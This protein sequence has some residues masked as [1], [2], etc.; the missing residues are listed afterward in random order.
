MHFAL[1][2]STGSRPARNGHDVSLFFVPLSPSAKT[3]ARHKTRARGFWQPCGPRLGLAV[4]AS[5]LCVF[6]KIW[7]RLFFAGPS[8]C[9]FQS[10][11]AGICMPLFGHLPATLE[12]LR[13][14]STLQRPPL[15]GLFQLWNFGLKALKFALDCLRTALKVYSPPVLQIK[16]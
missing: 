15:Q 7:E 5:N 2:Y 4:F 11:P 9:G 6:S 1:T 10:A 14:P 16:S 12:I 8:A 13:A 3:R